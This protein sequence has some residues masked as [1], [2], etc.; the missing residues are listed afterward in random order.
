MQSS[1]KGQSK[2]RRRRSREQAG[3]SWLQGELLSEVESSLSVEL[4]TEH[5]CRHFRA[6]VLLSAFLPLA[7]MPGQQ[8]SLGHAVLSHSW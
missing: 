7:L 4:H 8:R 3:A 1:D 2:V 5:C 6:R